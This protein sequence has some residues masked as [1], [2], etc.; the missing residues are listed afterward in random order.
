MF[1]P[2]LLWQNQRTW[3]DLRK[4]RMEYFQNLVK[5]YEGIVS[6]LCLVVDFLHNVQSDL[7]L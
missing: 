3:Q 2:S 1:K 4:E 6:H 5:T 7:S